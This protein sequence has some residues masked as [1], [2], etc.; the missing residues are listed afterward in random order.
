MDVHQKRKNRTVIG[1]NYTFLACIAWNIQTSRDKHTHMCR[2]CISQWVSSMSGRW[3][4]LTFE[5]PPSSTS[6][7]L[8]VLLS[9]A[10]IP[11][12]NSFISLGF[13]LC[14]DT[15]FCL[16]LSWWYLSCPHFFTVAMDN[17]MSIWHK[18]ELVERREP[19][20][21]KCLCKIQ[22]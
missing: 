11:S 16:Q 5:S 2:I 18:L 13:H 14:R 20:L 7:P 22:L 12:L 15:S 3:E 4:P 6:G 19:P 21:R 1:T 10:G 8:Y 17:F 9:Q